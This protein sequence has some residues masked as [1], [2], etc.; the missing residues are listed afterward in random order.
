MA[1]RGALQLST[2]VRAELDQISRS[3]TES[4]SMVRRAEILLSYADG[5]R[6]TAIARLFKTNRPLIER[7]VDKAFAFDPL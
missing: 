6:I 2:S 7:L 5:N 3:R 1:K 4:A